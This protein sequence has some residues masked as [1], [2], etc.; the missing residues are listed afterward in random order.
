LTYRKHY[1]QQNRDSILQYHQDRKSIRNAYKRE[2]RRVD[3]AFR[4][5]ES[6]KVRVHEVLKEYKD[7]SSSSLIGCTKQHIKAWL[8]Y[9]FNRYPDISWNNY[10]EY[11]HIDHV[12]PIAFFDITC[13]E[14]QRICFHWTNLRPY[15]KKDN[16]IKSDNILHN[17][18]KEHLE[19]LEQSLYEGYQ[20]KTDWW[21]RVKLW[22]GN[23]PDCS[24]DFRKILANDDPHG[25]R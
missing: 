20:T 17:D 6:L 10:A 19:F 9:Q 15:P 3:E 11:W 2:R 4:V 5:S 14:H 22:Y 12:I 1:Y 23:N 8:E 25:I 24:G 21:Q 7:T 16:I 18:I 13:K